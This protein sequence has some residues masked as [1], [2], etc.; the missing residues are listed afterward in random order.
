MA[1]EACAIRKQSQ[2]TH[3]DNSSASVADRDES[4]ADDAHDT[5]DG[6]NDKTQR[7]DRLNGIACGTCGGKC[8][9]LGGDHAFLHTS[10]LRRVLDERLGISSEALTDA[11]MQRIPAETYEKSCIYHGIHGCGLKR[12]GVVGGNARQPARKTGLVPDKLAWGR[13]CLICG[14]KRAGVPVLR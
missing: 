10:L 6:L 7:F 3:S 13:N 2:C 11:Y 14:F 9:N 4:D 1:Q 5:A 12:R 8:C